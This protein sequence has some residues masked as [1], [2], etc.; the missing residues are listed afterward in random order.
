MKKGKILITIGIILI[1][2]S[3]CLLSYNLFLSNKSKKEE[4]KMVPL[5]KEKIKEKDIE[6]EEKPDYYYNPN[7]SMPVSEIDGKKY[8]GILYFDSLNVEFPV[9]D[10][11]NNKNRLPSRYYGTAYLDN[12]IICAH[13]FNNSFGQLRKLKIGDMVIF[14]DIDGNIFEYKVTEV[15]LIKGTNIDEM[16]DTE[17]DLTLF[18]CDYN[19]T[20]RLTVRCERVNKNTY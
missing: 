11:W 4:T 9:L 18:T 8:V 10:S 14:E 17:W 1:L 16:K 6:I 20:R 7:I 13:N 15:L 19:N 2:L 3:F 12:M 5:I